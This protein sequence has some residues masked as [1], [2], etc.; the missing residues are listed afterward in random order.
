M[1]LVSITRVAN[2]EYNLTRWERKTDKLSRL[3][4]SD[5]LKKTHKAFVTG[6][7]IAPAVIEEFRMH[8]PE[9]LKI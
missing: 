6:V 7:S 5:K 2:N 4:G 1:I 8:P 3:M 9:R